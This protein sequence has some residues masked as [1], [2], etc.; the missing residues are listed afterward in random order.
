MQV[1][2]NNNFGI[3]ANNQKENH[4]FRFQKIFGQE[5][6]QDEVFDEVAR[7]VVDSCI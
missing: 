3:V 7:P 1:P 6:S 4:N 2:K 5:A